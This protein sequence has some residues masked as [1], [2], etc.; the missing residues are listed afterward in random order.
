MPDSDELVLCRN[1]LFFN[2]I[3]WIDYLCLRN[4]EKLSMIKEMHSLASSIPLS[5]Y[6]TEN[7]KENN[8][9]TLKLIS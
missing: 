8:S 3:I 7:V 4:V 9:D 6:V 1:Y 2:I 5:F